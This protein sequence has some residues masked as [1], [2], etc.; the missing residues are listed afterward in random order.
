MAI[1]SEVVEER[2]SDK[3]VPAPQPPAAPEMDE[4]AVRAA[5][6]AAEANGSDPAKIPLS[7]LAQGS[8]PKDQTPAESPVEVPEKFKKPTGEVDEEKLKASTEALRQSVQQKQEKLDE[9]KTVEDYIREYRELES[10]NS[11]L[12]NAKKTE[13]K[14]QE[15]LSQVQPP[16]NLTDQQLRERLAAD[17]QRDFVGTTSD[18]VDLIVQKRLEEKLKT[19]QE[20][21]E[22]IMADQKVSQM[23]DAIQAV[24]EKDPR[25]M[26]PGFYQAIMQKLKTEPTYWKLKNPFRSAWNDVRDEL[27]LEAPGKPEQAPSSKPASPILGGGTPPPSPSQGTTINAESLGRAIQ[28]SNHRNAQEMDALEKAARQLFA[29]YR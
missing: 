13:A 5:V 17:F 2:L 22:K 8:Q 20:P 3:Q 10:Q 12:P 25:V 15:A 1:E 29:N 19:V 28:G 9:L 26:Q 6:Q 14:T 21:L 18:L 24:A 16:Q 11:S 27:R 4:A 7:A 23:R